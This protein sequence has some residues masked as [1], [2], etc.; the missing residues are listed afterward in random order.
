MLDFPHRVFA[1]AESV[2]F[3]ENKACA[4]VPLQLQV[5]DIVHL[6]KKVSLLQCLYFLS[7]SAASLSL[8]LQNKTAG[9]AIRAH[10]LKPR[11]H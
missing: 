7:L 1:P 8:S 11:G 10:P 4:P 5:P 6:S 3:P 9:R 2:G